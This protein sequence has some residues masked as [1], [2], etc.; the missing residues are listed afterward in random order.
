MRPL[1]VGSYASPQAEELGI[2]TNYSG[3]YDRVAQRVTCKADA[4]L[5]CVGT[6]VIGI[7]CDDVR[8]SIRCGGLAGQNRV[9]L[10][11]LINS[12]WVVASR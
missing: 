1:P 7:S 2:T 4:P 5:S 12:Q 11:E 9:D 6:L 10:N 3:Q 8:S